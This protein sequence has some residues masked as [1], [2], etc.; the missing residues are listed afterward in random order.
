ML[1]KREDFD[2]F[3]DQMLDNAIQSFRSTNEY[4]LL[5]EKLDRM[6]TDCETM[7][8]EDERDF[9]AEC[10]ALLLDVAG[11]QERYVYRRGLLDCVA[12][13]KHLGVLTT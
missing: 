13:L 12:L 6:D 2:S 7:F 5:R 11:Q 1:N 4:G 8:R 10:F 9:A 3:M